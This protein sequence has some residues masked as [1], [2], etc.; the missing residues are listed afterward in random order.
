MKSFFIYFVVV[1]TLI[2]V[3]AVKY[4]CQPNNVS[5]G[6]GY[7][8]VAFSSARIVGGDDAVESSWSMIVSL[9]FYGS[10]EHSCAGTLLSESFILTAANCVE[11]FADNASASISIYAG[12][13]RQSDDG[14]YERNV[15]KI[16]IHPNYTGWPYFIND[17][18]L[19]EISSRLNFHNNPVI[20]RTCVHRIGESLLTHQQPLQNVTRL[21]IIG[22]GTIR[23]GSCALSDHLQQI[24]VT[25]IENEN[26][27]CKNA[28][29]ESKL[30]FC[31]GLQ[32]GAKG[33]I[34]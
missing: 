27:I 1:V 11:R 18:A 31:A 23:P 26:D 2:V 8:D 12:V 22:W 17:I 3:G 28:I 5:C 13:T 7:S 9:R 21:A 10:K 6:C 14:G 4:D 29:N 34:I 19:L 16:Y 15:V 24:Q 30:Q 32:N 33:N 20:G 25:V